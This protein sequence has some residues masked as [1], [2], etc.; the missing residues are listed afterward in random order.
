MLRKILY[1]WKH[2]YYFISSLSILNSEFCKFI[3]HVKLS[4]EEKETQLFS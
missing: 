1:I 3:N 2:I 4:I